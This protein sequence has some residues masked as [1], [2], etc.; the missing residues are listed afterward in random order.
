MDVEEWESNHTFI[1]NDFKAPLVPVCYILLKTSRNFYLLFSILGM[2][3]LK[4]DALKYINSL[5][6]VKNFLQDF[7]K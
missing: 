3:A 5:F 4:R 1:V 2:C 7:A 6:F